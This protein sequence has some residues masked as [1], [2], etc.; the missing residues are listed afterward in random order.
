MDDREKLG[1]PERSHAEPSAAELVRLLDVI[2][3]AFERAELGRRQAQAGRTV[4]LEALN[5]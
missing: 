3:G 4:P 5:D 1:T 2:P